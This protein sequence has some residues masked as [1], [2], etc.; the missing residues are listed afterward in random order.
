M[1]TRLRGYD[2]EKDVQKVYPARPQQ[3]KKR[4]VQFSTLSF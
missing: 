4:N 2:A 3:A 1:D